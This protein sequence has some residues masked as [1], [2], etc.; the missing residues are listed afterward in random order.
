ML[1]DKDKNEKDEEAEI[2]VDDFMFKMSKERAEY[3]EQ[4]RTKMQNYDLL[5]LFEDSPKQ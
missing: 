1:E 4:Q 3:L 2:I 5:D